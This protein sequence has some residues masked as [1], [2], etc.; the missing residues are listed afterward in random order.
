MGHWFESPFPLVPTPFAAL[1]EG[2]KQDV[3]V[4]TATGQ[5]KRSILVPNAMLI[6]NG[7]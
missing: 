7:F 4:A 2:E 5:Q 6:R 3:F 1:A